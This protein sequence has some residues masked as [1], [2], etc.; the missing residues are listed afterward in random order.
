M[1]NRSALVQELSVLCIEKATVSTYLP[2]LETLLEK[3]A[4]VFHAKSSALLGSN[5]HAYDI[6][7]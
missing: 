4:Y 3:W 7:E 5:K 2:C 1:I 6:N